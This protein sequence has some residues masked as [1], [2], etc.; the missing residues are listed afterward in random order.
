M[1]NK[2]A[3]LASGGNAPGMRAVITGVMKA[4][5]A[6]K[7]T[8]YI[9]A[10]GYYGLFHNQIEKLSLLMTQN[11]RYDNCPIIGSSRLV[12][13]KELEVRQ[14]AVKNLQAHEINSLIVIGG[15]GSYR[16]ALALDEMNVNCI[17]IPGT[18]DNDIASSRWTIGFDSCVNTVVSAIDKIR[19]SAD[20]HSRCLIVETMGR[21]CGDIAVFAGIAANVDLISVPEQK[22]S[23]AEIVAK[24]QSLKAQQQ[25][26]VIILVT[27]NMYDLSALQQAIA[28]TETYEV[29]TSVIGH[30]QRGGKASA[31]DRYLGYL[32]GVKAVEL[33]ANNESGY[34]LGTDGYELF[35]TKI[36][37]ALAKPRMS[38]LTMLQMFTHEKG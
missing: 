23:V 32:M 24:V 37:E 2:I 33:L 19:E 6:N 15:D 7:I 10:N 22:Y 30:I 13:F 14:E 29:R 12:E 8:P 11:L 27:E 26:S 36:H 35:K 31:K 20:W 17:A 21:A 25:K 18:I 3:V 28:Q 16:G 4:A 1:N 9:I 34:C 5:Q 38:H